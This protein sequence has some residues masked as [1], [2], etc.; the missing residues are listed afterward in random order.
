MADEQ[1]LTDKAIQS[2]AQLTRETAA[3]QFVSGSK[4]PFVIIPVGAK[5]ESLEKIVFNDHLEAP[6]RI[7]QAVTVRDPESFIE[8]FQKFADEDSTIFAD[9][10]SMTV[11]AVLDYH[12]S[13]EHPNWGQ[14]KVA[15]CLRE[16]EEWK[17]WTG[18]NN[19]AM[20]QMAFAEFLEQYSMDIVNP[21]PA[22]MMDVARDL[23][24]T[25]EVEFGAGSRTQDGQVRFKYVETTKATVGSGKLDVPQSFTIS[26]P[27]FIGGPRISMGALLRY[28]VKDTKLML[29]YTLVRPE[30]VKRAAFLVARDTIGEALDIKIINGIG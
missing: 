22:H 25:T 21:A 4:I 28:R 11:T 24:A 19:T 14:H 12:R 29:W 27:V 16:S 13:K 6:E 5:I 17:V 2:V 7:R 23:E 20:T 26:L 8:Y 3:P 10:P 18:K 1:Q 15:L 30:E 9:E